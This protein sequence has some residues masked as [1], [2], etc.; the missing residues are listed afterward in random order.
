MKIAKFI[1]IC[2]FYYILFSCNNKGVMRIAYL[3]N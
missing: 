3:S 2:I 1:S